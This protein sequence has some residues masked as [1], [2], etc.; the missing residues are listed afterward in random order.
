MSFV[1]LELWPKLLSR[2]KHRPCPH[3]HTTGYLNAHGFLRGFGLGSS[4]IIRGKRI[5]CSNR[6]RRKGCGKTHSLFLPNFIPTFSI[7]SS[8]L[9]N[10]LFLVLGGKTRRQA[11]K[12]TF[13]SKN[14]S[15]AYSFWKRCV[16]NQFN[17]RLIL[18]TFCQP[19]RSTQVIPWLQ[20]L[21]HLRLAF[22][23]S[24]NPISDFQTT[25][26]LAFL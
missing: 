17:L 2:L 6:G 22:P 10:F 24:P 23:L 11:F 9:W 7:L 5:Y 4:R 12:I 25:A 3:C 18:S 21:E 19:P 1:P 14:I 13:P 26:Q 8:L 20:V 16:K 15:R